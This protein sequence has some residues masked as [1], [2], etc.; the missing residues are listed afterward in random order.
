MKA[1]TIMPVLFLAHGSPMNIIEENAFTQMLRKTSKA[2]PHPKAIVVVSAHWVTRGSYVST[3]SVNVPQYDFYGFPD[4][5]YRVRYAPQG[6]PEMAQRIMERLPHI[7]GVSYR[8]DHGAWSVLL[9]LF[10]HAD[11]PVIQLSIDRT[12]S[13]SEHYALGKALGFLREEGVLLIGSGNVT[14]NLREVSFSGDTPVPK[15]AEQFDSYVADAVERGD[16][17]ALIA[18]EK[19][20]E[21]ARVAH[22]SDEH[23]LP[24][25]YILGA[26]G[27]DAGRVLFEGFQNGSVSMRSWCF[28]G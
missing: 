25:L 13:P 23:Y 22:P 21:A 10:P 4:P 17:E 19:A 24:L 6:S 11:I 3:D 1:K 28:G 20:G 8:L 14:H 27:A 16:H 9:H 5:L 7:S 15:W 12:L 26:A 18:Y 2:L